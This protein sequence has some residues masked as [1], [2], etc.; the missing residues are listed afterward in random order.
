MS[1]VI[2]VI[3]VV[4]FCFGNPGG[5]KGAVPLSVEV[6]PA[7]LASFATSFV[8]CSLASS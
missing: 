8:T 3:V 5:A 6:L 1:S 4:G 7:P 2:V